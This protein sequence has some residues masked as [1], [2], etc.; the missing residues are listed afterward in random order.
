LALLC[1]KVSVITPGELAALLTVMREGGCTRLKTEGLTIECGPKPAA[2][3]AD[4]GHK[5][6]EDD[7]LFAA[8]EGLPDGPPVEKG[9]H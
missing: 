3:P 1:L 2:L 5:L 6:S 4:R 9:K 8:S 7:W